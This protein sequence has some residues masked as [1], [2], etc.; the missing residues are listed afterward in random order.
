MNM[1]WLYN[2]KAR[3][4]QGRSCYAVATERAN[5]SISRNFHRLYP[6]GSA[7]DMILITW[8]TNAKSLLIFDGIFAIP[9]N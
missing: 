9:K 6:C 1:I 4:K 7:N 2:T 5:N 3:T 8:E